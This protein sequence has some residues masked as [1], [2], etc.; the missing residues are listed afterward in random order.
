M[1]RMNRAV[2]TASAAVQLD[3]LPGLRS[4]AFF[5]VE[6]ADPSPIGDVPA[7]L[8]AGAALQRFWLTATRLGLALQP[9]SALL[10]VAHYGEADVRFTDDARLRQKTRRV[11]SSFAQVFGATADSILFTGRI[12]QPK[13]QLPGSRSVRRRVA[14]LRTSDEE[15]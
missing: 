2:G 7:L 4:A 11:A 15:R 5:V 6:P 10:M 8:R 13:P 3:L 1:H 14:E 12:G 9:A